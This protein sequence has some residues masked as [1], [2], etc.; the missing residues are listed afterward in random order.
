M[1]AISSGVSQPETSSSSP[2]LLCASAAVGGYFS[3]RAISSLFAPSSRMRRQTA[4]A[5]PACRLL[6]EIANDPKARNADRIAAARELFDRGWGKAPEFASIEGADPLEL[7]GVSAEI[8][9]IADE[10]RA[11]REARAD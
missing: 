1:K 4:N 11:R 9:A 2:A 10:L 3:A 8:Q 5:P 7:D 6:L